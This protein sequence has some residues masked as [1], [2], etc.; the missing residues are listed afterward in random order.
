MYFFPSSFWTVSI[1]V[2][3]YTSTLSLNNHALLHGRHFLT[4]WMP[5]LACH[6][7]AVQAS[8]T[9]LKCAFKASSHL[10]SSS[11][12]SRSAGRFVFL[13]SWNL[14]LC[15]FQP[16]GLSYTIRGTLNNMQLSSKHSSSSIWRQWQRRLLPH[17]LLYT[18]WPRSFWSFF[19]PSNS[20]PSHHAVFLF[21]LQM[22]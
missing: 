7:M 17:S 4:L 22:F 16:F 18:N 19:T 14:F 8:L 20:Q 5:F 3:E 10:S 15:R 1:C 9:E 12:I 21:L 6:R 11:S 2:G 13:L